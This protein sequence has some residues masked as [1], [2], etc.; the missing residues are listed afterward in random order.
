MK[1]R[2]FHGYVQ[3]RRRILDGRPGLRASWVA[4]AVANY[5]VKEFAVAS[6]VITKYNEAGID[7]AEAYEEGEFLLFQNLCLE[8]GGKYIEAI[9][10]L[11]ANKALIVDVLSWRIKLGHL[12]LLSKQFAEARDHWKTLLSE[13][14]ENYRFH[15]GLQAALL[16]LE[17]T[18][19]TRA[20]QLK[21]LALPCTTLTLSASQHT[22][23][24]DYYAQNAVAK[25]K[26]FEKIHLFLLQQDPARFEAALH[27]FIQ[28][29]VNDGVPSLCQDIMALAVQPDPLDATS[30]VYPSDAIEFRRHTTVQTALRVVQQLLTPDVLS[31]LSPIAELWLHYLHAHLLWKTGD[32]SGATQAIEAAIAHTPTALDMY[33]FKAK[34]LKAQGDFPSAAECMDQCRALDLQDRY[35]NNKATKYFLRNDDVDSAFNTIALFTKHDADG[36]IQKTLYDLQV[37]SSSSFFSVCVF[38]P[39]CI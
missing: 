12:L 31:T 20:L 17:G 21:R 38:L 8:K 1:M 24:L 4:F 10:H 37:T 14:P 25:S 29:N 30:S 7:R 23:L 3:S 28:K 9:A 2:D 5:A 36:D 34:L 11:R 15:A 33:S 39:M 18:A 19:L 16:E 6:D 35:L 32:L 27:A 22:L 13:Q 26:A